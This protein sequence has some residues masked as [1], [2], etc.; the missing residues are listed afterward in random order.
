MNFPDT[1]PPH[2][3]DWSDVAELQKRMADTVREM[4]SLADEVGLAR[5]VREFSSDQRKRAL[6]R[7]MQA[8]LAGGESAAK[9]EAEARGSDTYGKELEILSRQLTAA[10][11][12]IAK[13]DV[14]K[15]TW[16]SVRSMLAM[17]REATKL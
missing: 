14:L 6:A 8:A 4:D 5:Q 1:S 17:Q 9:A 11:Q 16:E 7:A 10:E 12:I 13:W 3:A 2:A 15:I